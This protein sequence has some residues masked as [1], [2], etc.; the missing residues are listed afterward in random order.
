ME[1]QGGGGDGR[2]CRNR[3][4]H[5]PETGPRRFAGG[6]LGQTSR[7]GQGAVQEADQGGCQREVVRLQGGRDAGGG[8][9]AGVQ[10]DQREFGDD[11]HTH[12]Q[13]RRHSDHQFNRRQHG[14][15]EE[16]VRHERV[17]FVL[18]EGG[19][20]LKVSF[21]SLCCYKGGGEEYEREQSGWTHNP[22]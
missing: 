8:T 5:L 13:R 4:R 21:R 7:D 2:Q 11:T 9:F 15:V 18:L 12:Q 20:K 6:G 10:V 22:H 16:S 17:R 14:E 1:G 3:C 19:V